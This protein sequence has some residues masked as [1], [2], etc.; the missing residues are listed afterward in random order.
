MRVFIWFTF[1]VLVVSCKKSSDSTSQQPAQL[2]SNVSNIGLTGISG[3]KDSIIITSN[4]SWTISVSPS[5][6][7][8]SLSNSAGSNNGKVY[9]TATQD[10]TTGSLR[11]TSITLTPVGTSGLQP[12]DIVLTQSSQPGSPP[13]QTNALL[14]QWLRPIGTSAIDLGNTI[15][16]TSSG[17]FI[18]GGASNGYPWAANADSFG[19][20]AWQKTIGYPLLY[21]SVRSIIAASD[22][23]YAVAGWVA[24][25]NIT[26]D[27]WVAKFNSSGDT[28]WQKLLG[29]S[30]RNFSGSDGDYASSIAAT[31]DGGFIAAGYTFC[32]DGDVSGNHGECDFWVIKFSNLGDVLWKKVLGG[33]KRDQAWC[34]INA[35]DGGY[36][37]AGNSQSNDGD[38]TGNNGDSDAWIIKLNDAGNLVW[39]YSIGGTSGD[40]IQSIVPTADGTGYIAAGST[41][42]TDGNFSVNH[43]GSDAW[44]LKLNN[45][46]AVL[47]QKLIGTLYDESAS[48]VTVD[49]KGEVVI[50]GVSNSNFF[51]AK[52]SKDGDLLS[53]G[54][55]GSNVWTAG[56]DPSGK[57]I[58]AAGE[59]YF[60]TFSTAN[61]SISGYHGGNTDGVV[62]KF[63]FE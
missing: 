33:N 18:I 16:V 13:L 34:V 43:G 44:I 62:T 30:S 27:F 53:Q 46:G 48:S 28:L 52:L 29:G 10:N 26:N 15:A 7:W 11:S 14:V 36:I 58:V 19:S 45:N 32:N 5:V 1:F 63:K 2:K 23:G 39:Q 47:W 25:N 49:S 35:N 38:V 24:R 20:L 37:I 60:A 21:G 8:A 57:T 17:G 6:G 22:G 4:I 56:L 54:T 41:L 3:S 55:I 31:P 50:A 12:V 61:S 9:V 59:Y 40:F 51:A 42:S